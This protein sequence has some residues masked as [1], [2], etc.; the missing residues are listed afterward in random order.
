MNSTN[1]PTS[2]YVAGGKSEISDARIEWWERA[3]YNY[4]DTDTMYVVDLKTAGRIDLIAQA[5]L[6]DSHLWWL[7]AQYN[8]ILDVTAEIRVGRVL[9]IPSSNRVQTL[10]NGKLG[11]FPSTRTIP[12]NN[13]TPIV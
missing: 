12:L 3:E 5:Y 1:S 10:L 9:H 8:S 13:I 11:G 4:S 2:R 7:I 6:G